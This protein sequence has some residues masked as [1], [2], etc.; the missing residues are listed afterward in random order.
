MDTKFS[1]FHSAYTF[2]RITNF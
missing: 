2:A 1:A